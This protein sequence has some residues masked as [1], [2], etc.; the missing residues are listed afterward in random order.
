MKY[1]VSISFNG[2]TRKDRFDELSAN[3]IDGDLLITTNDGDNAWLEIFEEDFEVSRFMGT[4]HLGS[5]E[6]WTTAL[7]EWT[8]EEG[9]FSASLV[10]RDTDEEVVHTRLFMN[11]ESTYSRSAFLAAA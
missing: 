6:N 7:A 11:G 1:L 10:V 2:E 9:D 3:L 5:I 8:S 4:T